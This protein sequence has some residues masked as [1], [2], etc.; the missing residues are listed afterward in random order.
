[1]PAGW[2]RSEPLAP[3]AMPAVGV[4][5]RPRRG[6]HKQGGTVPGPSRPATSAPA[7]AAR[8]TRQRAV[9]SSP[10][11]CAGRPARW[12]GREVSGQQ[13]STVS[14][15]AVMLT[16]AV[17]AAPGSSTA[18]PCATSARCSAIA[19]QSPPPWPQVWPSPSVGTAPGVVPEGSVTAANRSG[20][21]LRAVH[22]HARRHL[23]VCNFDH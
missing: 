22:L 7:R 18:T 20:L 23:R 13:V 5:Q 15:S 8:R 9:P 3:D 11:G 12:P 10:A 4:R 14:S 16:S 21:T 19:H 1:M 6:L 2:P 17:R